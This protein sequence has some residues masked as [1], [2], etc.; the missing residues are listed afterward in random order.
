MNLLIRSKKDSQQIV[1]VTRA[2]T[3]LRYISFSAYQLAPG[4]TVTFSDGANELCAVVLSGIVS[5]QTDGHDWAEI[6]QRMSV[7]EDAAPYAVYIP[8]RS[9]LTIT[10]KTNAELGVAGGPAKGELPARLIEPSAIRRSVRGKGSNTRYVCDILPHKHDLDN[11]PEESL[12]EE[13][14]YHRI[15]PPQGFIFQRVYTDSRDLDESM[16]VGDRDVVL[17]PRG[18]HPVVVPH[19]YES[20]YFNVMAGPKRVWHFHNDPDHEWILL[21]GV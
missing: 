14:Y 6:G 15:N 13:T 12:L 4:Q 9:K 1:S 11:V 21:S 8:P 10:A 3:G 18:Y 2:S 17:V 16:A 19:G 7:F 20:Y 5:A